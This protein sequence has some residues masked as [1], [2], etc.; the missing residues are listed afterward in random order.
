[1]K[2]RAKNNGM[3][4]ED[5]CNERAANAKA[6][7]KKKKNRPLLSKLKHEETPCTGRGTTVGDIPT[8]ESTVRNRLKAQPRTGRMPE[9]RGKT[10]HNPIQQPV[11]RLVSL[12]RESQSST[13]QRFVGG[14]LT[15]RTGPN[16]KRTKQ[17]N[18]NNNK[19]SQVNQ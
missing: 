3:V 17:T 7:S 16:R 9:K 10:A 8:K 15:T 18:N 14:I 1:M 11:Q 12:V 6:D 5:T 4:L 2:L 19:T 13:R